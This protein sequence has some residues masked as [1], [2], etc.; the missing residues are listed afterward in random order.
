MSKC[1]DILS[2]IVLCS[3]LV[4][5]PIEMSGN[6]SNDKSVSP[7]QNSTV[8]VL[9]PCDHRGWVACCITEKANVA[10]FE[11]CL[12]VWSRDDETSVWRFKGGQNYYQL[13]PGFLSR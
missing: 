1:I 11:N 13:S 6:I 5:L 9:G 3:A 12:V 2:D 10:V 7:M 4:S 8:P